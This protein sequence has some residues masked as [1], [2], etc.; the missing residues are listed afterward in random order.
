MTH[1]CTSPS[2]RWILSTDTNVI[3][4]AL[5]LFPGARCLCGMHVIISAG[6]AGSGLDYYLST[7]ID[8]P[9]ALEFA[10]AHPELDTWT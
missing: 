2:H 8:S 7:R 4:P 1:R 10:K 5:H 3:R 6:S 9:Q